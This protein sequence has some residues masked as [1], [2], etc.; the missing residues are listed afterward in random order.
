MTEPSRYNASLADAMRNAAES[1]RRHD[2]DATRHWL[3][4]A[5]RCAPWRIDIRFCL[6]GRH[7]Q[8]GVA[9]LAVEEYERILESVPGEIGALLFSAHW[10]RFLE[11]DV[12]AEKRLAQI[13]TVRPDMGVALERVWS[14]L[15]VWQQRSVRD[16]PR[17]FSRVPRNPAILILGLLLNDD[18][19]PR[20]GLIARLEKGMELYEKYPNARI[21]VSGGVPRSGC[22][23]AVIMSEW[24]RKKGVAAEQIYEEGYSRDIVENLIFSRQILAR[25]NVDAVV[26]VTCAVNIRRTGSGLGILSER[27]G[28]GWEVEAVAASGATYESFTDDGGDRLKLYRDSLRTFGIPMMASYPYLAER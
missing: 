23:E 1:Y 25:L 5:L 12:I 22:V 18:G 4:E 11:N 21:I 19:S 6:A 9:E 2:D 24:L 26:G 15:D 8:H 20:P 13:Q 28:L 7:I 17:E 16:A 14:H 3:E 27:Y 10:H